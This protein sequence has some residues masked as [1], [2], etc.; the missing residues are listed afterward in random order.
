MDRSKECH[1]FTLDVDADGS[2][3]LEEIGT[4]FDCTFYAAAE[5]IVETL[6]LLGWL[7]TAEMD[8]RGLEM[9]LIAGAFWFFFGLPLLRGIVCMVFEATVDLIDWMSTRSAGTK[10]LRY[11]QIALSWP[12]EPTGGP[13]SGKQRLAS[14]GTRGRGR[15]DIADSPDTSAHYADHAD[16]DAAASAVHLHGRLIRDVAARYGLDAD[17]VRAIMYVEVGESADV[18]ARSH[19]VVNGLRGYLYPMTSPPG[20]KPERPFMPDAFI[21]PRANIEASCSYL[22]NLAS[23]IGEPTVA[24]LATLYD[25]PYLSFVSRYGARVAQ[26]YQSRAWETVQPQQPTT[27]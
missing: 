4:W 6:G 2:I 26:V 7:D 10:P 9:T 8:P 23:R 15:I 21:S 22:K 19:V 24:R 3:S 13:L 1:W 5:N 18:R 14:L 25:D 12:T 20:W 11:P 27:Q 16:H 17:L